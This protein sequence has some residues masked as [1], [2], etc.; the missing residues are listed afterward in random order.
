MTSASGA[1]SSTGASTAASASGAA[2]STAA[3]G[4]A[5]SS[6]TASSAGA[7]AAF[8]ALRPLAGAGAAASGAAALRLRRFGVASSAGSAGATERSR[9]VMCAVRLRIRIARPRARGCQ[10]FIVTP[11]SANASSTTRDSSSSPWLLTAFAIA[12]SST[13]RMSS[14]AWRVAN[15]SWTRAS[16]TGRPRTCSSTIRALRADVRTHLAWARTSPVSS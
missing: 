1:V 16:A 5:V 10:R 12:E 15:R 11:S 9:I 4:A 3:S 6:A 14:A 7:S 2:S 8:A 13:R